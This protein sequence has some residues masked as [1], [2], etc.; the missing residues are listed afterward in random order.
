MSIDINDRDLGFL[1]F[2][3]SRESDQH[4]V[5]DRDGVRVVLYTEG[6]PEVIRME[7]IGW[8]EG[9]VG[10]E[11]WRSVFTGSTPRNLLITFL[12]GLPR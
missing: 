12:K 3:L 7:V 9:R 8:H 2:E 5:W 1:G 4:S 6:E 11:A 10:V